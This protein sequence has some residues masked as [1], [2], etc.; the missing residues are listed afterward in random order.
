MALSRKTFGKPE[1]FPDDLKW[2]DVRD[3]GI[4]GKGWSNTRRYFDRF[5]AQAK[6]SVREPV[7]QL[8]RHSAGMAVR[9]VS[10]AAK[11][12]VRYILLSDELALSN[13]PATGVSGLDLYAEDADGNMRWVSVVAPNDQSM[14]IAIADDLIPRKQRY[15]LYLPLH[16]SVGALSIGVPPEAAFEPVAPRT[17]PPIVFYGTSI[18]QGLCASRPGMA[19]PAILGRRLNHPYLNLGF[20]GH[21]WMDLEVGALMGELEAAVF[22][23]DCLPNMGEAAITARTVPFVRQLRAA[24]PDTPILLVEDRTFANTPFFNDRAGYLQRR[25]NAYNRAYQS[26]LAEGIEQLYYLAG[27]QL[28]GDDGEATTD[29]SHPND[30]GMMR[31]ADAYEPVLRAILDSSAGM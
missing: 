29:G 24:R 13:M 12:Q 17:K 15:T 14:D 8:S 4:E 27:D 16:N 25:R 21:G 5:P 30:L 7:W 1:D 9:F 26:L 3:W 23:L 18:M 10:D 19:F 20:S 11:I 6:A 31:Y 2:H 28:L 22:V